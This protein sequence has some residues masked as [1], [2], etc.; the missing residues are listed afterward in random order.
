MMLLPFVW[1]LYQEWKGWVPLAVMSFS[2]FVLLNVISDTASLE[3][4]RFGG[5]AYTAILRSDE[6]SAEHVR[7]NCTIPSALLRTLADGNL[8]TASRISLWA[9]WVAQLGWLPQVWAY[10]EGG[11]CSSQIA[12]SSCTHTLPFSLRGLQGA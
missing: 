9:L 8:G 2:S 4:Y 10:H 12:R 5:E 1:M 11:G 7:I 3:R 6:I